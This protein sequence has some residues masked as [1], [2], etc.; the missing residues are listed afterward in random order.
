M[1]KTLVVQSQQE[2]MRLDI[3]LTESLDF[4]RS[5]LNKEIKIKKS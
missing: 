4:S 1:N 5:K 2:G 3:F